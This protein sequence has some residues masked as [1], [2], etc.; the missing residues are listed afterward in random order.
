MKEIEDYIPRCEQEEVDK[1]N[2][3]LLC[4]KFDNLLDRD[5]S[6]A[7]FTSSSW[8]VN[9]QRTKV[10]MIYHKIYHSWSW[11]GGHVDGDPDFLQV[12]LREAKEETGIDVVPVSKE[13]IALD[14][15]HVVPH[16][17][18]GRFLS[19]HLH[20]NVT[21]L[22]EADENDM[23]IV[24]EE[25]TNGVKWIPIE[26]LDSYISLED[27]AMLRVYHKLNKRVNEFRK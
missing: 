25:E 8:I 23:L 16:I 11:T 5:N 17:K 26:Q 12:A 24:N 7:H 19:A 21:Y 6:I 20:L 14:I 13:I 18:K 22:M 15:L 3:M 4:E 9:K 27:I 10:L 1:Q 2:I